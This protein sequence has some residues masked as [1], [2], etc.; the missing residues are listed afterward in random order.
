MNLSH[1]PRE[2][3]AVRIFRGTEKEMPYIRNIQRVGAFNKRLERMQIWELNEDSLA[4]E[5]NRL[6][7]LFPCDRRLYWLAWAR[8]MELGLICGGNYADNCEFEAAG[9]LLVNPRCVHIYL[10][11]ASEPVLKKRHIPLS[12]QT[13]FDL[14]DGL[15]LAGLLRDCTITEIKEKPLLVDLYE[16]LKDSGRIASD[17]LLSVQF[18]M[19]RMADALGFLSAWNIQDSAA[20]QKRLQKADPM[21]RAFVE[22]NLCRFD[23][24]LFF[25]IGREIFNMIE[26][27]DYQSGFICNPQPI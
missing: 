20:L 7:S 23:R 16:A 12:E 14:P 1:I 2:Y 4:C 5:R 6:Q 8:L 17:Y 19:K 21:L 9:D 11:G 18:R 26:N 15:N 3:T 24:K 10:E 22:S 27:P 25:T 13:G